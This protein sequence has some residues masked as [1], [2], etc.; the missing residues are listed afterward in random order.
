MELHPSWFGASW[1]ALA[2]AALSAVV[3][4]LTVVAYTRVVGLRSF[5]KM[6]S[7]DFAGTV[8]VGSAIAT[9]ALSRTVPLATGVVAIGA[10]FVVQWG[11]SL[12]RQRS[13]RA[14]AVLE[15]DP[16]LLMRHGEVLHA[17]LRRAGVAIDDVRSKLREANVLDLREVRAMV[18]E[19]TGDVTVLHGGPDGPDIDPWLLE[20][21]RER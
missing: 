3:V 7:V 11:L 10:L 12:L 17:N 5:A 2:M 19:T 14:G 6:S 4:F 8:A 13:P 15:N 16:I 1:G 9:V 18:F 20:G 21:V